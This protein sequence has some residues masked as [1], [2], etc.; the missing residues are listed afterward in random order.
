MGVLRITVMSIL[1]SVFGQIGDLFFSKIKRENN[2]KDY[3]H[4]IKGHGGI[5]DRLDS[6]I[7]GVLLYTLLC[8]IL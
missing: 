1:I 3:S 6:L 5:L 2:I 8:T 7:F 4:L